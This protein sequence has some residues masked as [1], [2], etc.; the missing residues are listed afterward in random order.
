MLCLRRSRCKSP[1]CFPLY[2]RIA[3]ASTGGGRKGQDPNHNVSDL[4]QRLNLTEEEEAIADFSDDEGEMEPSVV[5]WALVV[6]V[7][8]P[9]AVHVNTVCAAMK[10]AWGNPVGLKFHAIGEKQTIC[11]S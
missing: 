5:E 3:T 9:M 4:L 11:L 7:L 10:P 2:D 8:S 6:K 1:I